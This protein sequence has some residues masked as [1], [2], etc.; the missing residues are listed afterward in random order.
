MGPMISQTCPFTGDP[1]DITGTSFLLQAA[2]G[3]HR[4]DVHFLP[5]WKEMLIPVSGS[6]EK[7]LPPS[8]AR[9]S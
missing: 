5:D 4:T 7:L 9:F 6:G 1:T 2:T 8:S 3:S